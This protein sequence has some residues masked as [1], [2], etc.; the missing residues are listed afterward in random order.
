[1]AAPEAFSDT[2]EMK[3]YVPASSSTRPAASVVN[4]FCASVAAAATDVVPAS[5]IVPPVHVNVPP[6]N[7][8]VPVPPSV[9]AVI[10]FAPDTVTLDASAACNVAPASFT[11]PGNVAPDSTYVP[12]SNSTVP[13]AAAPPKLPD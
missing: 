2:S 11:C 6:V 9:P 5:D 12:A 7:D 1:G 13:A 4:P 8:Q 3:S 10:V